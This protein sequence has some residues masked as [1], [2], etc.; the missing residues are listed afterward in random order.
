MELF[1]SKRSEFQI[2]EPKDLSSPS[3]LKV[4]KKL[5]QQTITL[6]TLK[7]SL[8][9]K[10]DLVLMILVNHFNEKLFFSFIGEAN[11]ETFL[12]DVAGK[13]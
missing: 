9:L 8:K 3:P 1:I 10:S 7:A 6:I 5:K 11:R 4:S 12:Y 2:K 13:D